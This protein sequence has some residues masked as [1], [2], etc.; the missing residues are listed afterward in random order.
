MGVL[1]EARKKAACENYA[2]AANHRW[3]GFSVAGEP[4]PPVSC[5]QRTGGW[6]WPRRVGYSARLR[7]MT[8]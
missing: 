7:R 1:A 5:W 8:A 2:Q 4:H 6:R 3:I